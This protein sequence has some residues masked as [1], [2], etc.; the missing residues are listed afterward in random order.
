MINAVSVCLN[1]SQLALLPTTVYV[2]TLSIYGVQTITGTTSYQE[3]VE[4]L[5]I[6][7]IR[8]RVKLTLT[9]PI[10]TTMSNLIVSPEFSTIPVTVE[11][12]PKCMSFVGAMG[13]DGSPISSQCVL[14]SE[15]LKPICLTSTTIYN[16]FST[17][18]AIA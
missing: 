4:N 5:E 7:E 18:L 2:Q 3:T 15:P 17:C 6:L 9:D 12:T 14:Y 16:A 10:T 13:T 8:N 11:Y 1:H